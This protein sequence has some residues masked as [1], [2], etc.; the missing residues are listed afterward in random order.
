MTELLFKEEVY[1]IVGAAM[2]IHRVLGCGF[3]EPMY[4]EALQIELAERDIP[5]IS[6]H[7]L[8]VYFINSR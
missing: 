4:Q 3:L 8:P 2:E 5:Y 6:Q 7:E 1:A